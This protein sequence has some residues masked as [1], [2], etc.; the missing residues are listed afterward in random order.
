M[1]GTTMKKLEREREQP[2]FLF[3]R[4]LQ[5]QHQ[6][7]ERQGTGWGKTYG[8]QQRLTVSTTTS[9][10]G[11]KARKE[12]RQK[13]EHQHQK[14]QQQ[15]EMDRAKDN[16]HGNKSRDGNEAGIL[17]LSS[18]VLAT[19]ERK[20]RRKVRYQRLFHLEYSQRTGAVERRRR[21]HNVRCH[22]C[23]T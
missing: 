4:E 21:L 20:R 11:P 14:H 10:W 13:S 22:R 23:A 9:S 1:F 8:G 3:W 18:S 7:K 19:G 12:A 16:A 5:R 6:K 15:Q 17:H 2:F